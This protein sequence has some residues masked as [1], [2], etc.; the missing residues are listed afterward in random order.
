MA[1]L[2]QKRKWRFGLVSLF[3]RTV[4]C[5]LGSV[6]CKWILEFIRSIKKSVIDHCIS[7]V[8]MV[9]TETLVSVVCIL[10]KETHSS[11]LPGESLG[12]RS[13]VGYSPWGR[14]IGHD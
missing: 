8:V 5:R 1:R 11:T 3:Y 7:R 14:S 2:S 9:S 12:Q 13:L 6:T 10:E 4:F